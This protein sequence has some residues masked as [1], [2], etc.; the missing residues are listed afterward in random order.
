[1]TPDAIE[2]LVIRL[3]AASG[4]REAVDVDFEVYADALENVPDDVGT[5]AGKYLTCTVDLVTHRPSPAMVRDQAQAI[6]RRR[7]MERPAIEEATGPP[8]SREA[9]LE[10]V[11]RIKAAHGPSKMADALEKV[12]QRQP[13]AP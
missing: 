3:Y 11:R 4:G 13:E 9:S 7:D 2:A 10:W 5:E 1:M 8:A 12:A 6:M